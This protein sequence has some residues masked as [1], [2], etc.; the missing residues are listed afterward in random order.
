MVLSDR[1]YRE[2]VPL[3]KE[4]VKTD[5]LNAQAWLALGLAF[6]NMGRNNEAKA[7]YNTYLKLKPTGA[8]ADEVRAALE[9]LKNAISIEAC[10]RQALL[11]AVVYLQHARLFRLTRSRHLSYHHTG[12][13]LTELEVRPCH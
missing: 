3:L 11:L 13:D 9:Q 2:A 10:E 8:M 12:F 4:S 1:G 6:Q 7:P 5:P